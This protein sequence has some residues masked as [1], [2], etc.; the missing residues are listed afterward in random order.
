[1]LKKK[2]MPYKKNVKCLHACVYIYRYVYMMWLFNQYYM[3]LICISIVVEITSGG[4]AT[5]SQYPRVVSDIND[6]VLTE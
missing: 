1:M 6:D 3:Y 4:E 2:D 5:V